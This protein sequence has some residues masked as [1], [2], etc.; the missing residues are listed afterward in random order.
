MRTRIGAG[1]ALLLAA[2]VAGA[3]PPGPTADPHVNGHEPPPVVREFHQPVPPA[4]R[5]VTVVARSSPLREAKPDAPPGDDW[6][7]LLR[8]LVRDRGTIL[9][10]PA[11]VPTE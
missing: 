1:A 6:F 9:L 3:K 8:S 5:Q 4:A 10:G 2:G 7:G 11:T